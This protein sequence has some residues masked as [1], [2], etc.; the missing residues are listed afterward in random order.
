M[1]DSKFLNRRAALLL[2]AGSATLLA[3]PIALQIPAAL[4]D[5][6]GGNG[7]G[8]GGGGEGGGGNGGGNHDKDNEDKDNEDKDNEAD[9]D[10]K[11]VDANDTPDDNCPV[12]TNCD[13]D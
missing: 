6:D 7:G 12:G 13:K 5:D 11:G 8:E 3:V 4:A 1:F 2:L 9:K 10:T